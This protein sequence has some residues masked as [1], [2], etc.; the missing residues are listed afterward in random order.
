MRVAVMLEYSC[1]AHSSAH[2]YVFIRTL[3][4]SAVG[5][6]SFS[7]DGKKEKKENY[8]KL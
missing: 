4:T 1:L 2:G 6:V 7:N 3:V 8:S 5:L